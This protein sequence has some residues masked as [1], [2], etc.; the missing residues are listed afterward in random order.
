MSD[1][2]VSVKGAAELLGVHPE[3]IRRAIRRK[4]L[5]AQKEPFSKGPRYLISVADLKALQEK[6]RIG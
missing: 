1:R 3:T 2:F 4:E 6:R 5:L